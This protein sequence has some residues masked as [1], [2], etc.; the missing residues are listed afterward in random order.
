MIILVVAICFTYYPS[1][2]L[3]EGVLPSGI[4]DS[5][6]GYEIESYIENHKE[7]TASIS[8]AVFRGEDTCMGKCDAALGAETNKFWCRC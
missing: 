2:V 8:T 6:I 3:A 4:S 5:E 7:T 1:S